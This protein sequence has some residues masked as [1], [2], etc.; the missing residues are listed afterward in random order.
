[1]VKLMKEYSKLLKVEDQN[2]SYH[3][4]AFLQT[5]GVRNKGFQTLESTWRTES[6]VNSL[7]ELCN[8]KHD[9]YESA[10]DHT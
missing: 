1:M 5:S 7:C 2:F 6:L 10:M 3:A 9:I 4:Y 8:D